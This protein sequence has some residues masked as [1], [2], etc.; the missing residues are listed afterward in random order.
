MRWFLITLALCFSTVCSAQ[1]QPRPTAAQLLGNEISALVV[2]NAQLMEQVQKLSDQI[3]EL[4][5]Q[6]D[7]EK[8]NTQPQG[9]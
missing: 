6:L 3:V 9:K 5:K 4:Q 8:A 2:Q 1:T 7:Q